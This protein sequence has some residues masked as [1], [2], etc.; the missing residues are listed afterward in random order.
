MLPSMLDHFQKLKNK[1]ESSVLARVYG[2][3]TVKLEGVNAVHLMIMRNSINK[4]QEDSTIPYTFDLKGSSIKRRALPKHFEKL[5]K[6]KQ[7]ILSNQILKDEDLRKIMKK[8]ES[9][10]VNISLVARRRV[11]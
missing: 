10:L 7:K 1:R 4:T 5:S 9:N 8:V 2:L 3:Y 6:K 11:I